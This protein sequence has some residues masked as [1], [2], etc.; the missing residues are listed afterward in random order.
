MGLNL[1]IP[2]HVRTLEELRAFSTTYWKTLREHEHDPSE[3]ELGLL[4]P[5]HVAE[6]TR[7]AER[8]AEA[9]LMSYYDVIRTTRAAYAQWLTERGEPLPERLRT[10]AVSGGIAYARVCEEFAAIG[11]AD[12]VAERIGKLA[13]ETGAGHILAWMNIGSMAH[14]H[15]K[16]SM[17]RFAKD[18]LPAVRALEPGKP[19]A[20]TIPVVP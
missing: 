18:A 20:Q 15:V 14:E 4:L 5:L 16:D 9:G 17:K 7:A 10:N 3:H 6:T 13:Q 19:H 1:F 8:R 12:R 2:V 11:T